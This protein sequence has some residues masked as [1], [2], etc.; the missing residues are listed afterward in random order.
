MPGTRRRSRSASSRQATRPEPA[1]AGSPCGTE[2][3]GRGSAQ[4]PGSARTAVCRAGTRPVEPPLRAC[5]TTPTS[6]CWTLRKGDR[7]RGELAP[8]GVRPCVD[9]HL[10]GD[11]DVRTNATARH[12][13]R[14][15]LSSTTA[16]TGGTTP[17]PRSEWTQTV[18]Y[19][20]HVRNLTK[21]HPGIPEPLRGTYA[22]MAHPVTIA[23]L[24]AMGVTTV[25][26]LPVHAF[27]HEPG[28]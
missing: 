4:F 15:L 27:S 5:A 17:R 21:R 12:T 19:E 25:E 14:G 1:N 13:Y 23:H 10:H 2:R 8:R 16:S 20:T 11:P 3:T 28:W 26:L 6:S 9:A 22:G 7:G 18:I 24:H